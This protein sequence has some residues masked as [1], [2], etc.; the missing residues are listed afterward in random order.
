MMTV[1]EEYI[2]PD[3]CLRF[4]VAASSDGDLTLCF[5]GSGGFTGHTH[6]DIIA[7]RSGQP[8]AKAARQYVDDLL[9]DRAVIALLGG[10]GVTPAVWVVDDPA[11]ALA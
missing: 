2:S 6:A 3:G 4:R 11:E 1:L 5:V 8:A 7:A 10:P 9:G